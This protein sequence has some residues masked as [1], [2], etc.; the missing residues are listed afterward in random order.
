[1]AARCELRRGSLAGHGEAAVPALVEA[2]HNRSP[3][4]K[5][6]VAKTLGTIASP[7]AIKALVEAMSEGDFD[8]H[9]AAAH[10]LPVAGLAALK[11]VLYGLTGMA[12][13]PGS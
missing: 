10:G 1:M 2:L 6:E 7:E 8:I 3:L 9:Y 5:D 11:P 4:I 12:T 13:A